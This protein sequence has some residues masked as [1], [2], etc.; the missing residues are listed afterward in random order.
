MAG[1]GHTSVRGFV[2]R[3]LIGSRIGFLCASRVRSSPISWSRPPV[4]AWRH[5][6]G[7]RCLSTRLPAAVTDRAGRVVDPGSLIASRVGRG[8]PGRLRACPGSGICHHP[9]D[10]ALDVPSVEVHLRGDHPASE[11]HR[12]RALPVALGR[13]YRPEH[14]RCAVRAAG[15]PLAHERFKHT[16]AVAP[17]HAGVPGGGLVVSRSAHRQVK[18]VRDRCNSR[19][20]GP[21]RR[22]RCVH[23]Q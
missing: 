4:C 15:R 18:R 23:R 17:A 11:R 3:R 12:R 9:L 21:P 22:P 5:R 19:R 2:A 14:P 13:W 1:P 8:R 10:A 7:G 6:T 16:C 20:A